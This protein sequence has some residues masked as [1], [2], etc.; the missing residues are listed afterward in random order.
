MS[1]N[2]GFSRRG[3]A[4]VL[5]AGA[6]LCAAAQTGA[7]TSAADTIAETA[8][9]HDGRVEAVDPVAQAQSLKFGYLSYSAALQ[10]MPDYA[11][12]RKQM[13][14]LKAKYDAEARR[15]EDEFNEKYEEFLEGQ[16]DFPQSI[17]EKRQNELQELLDRNIAFR[18]ESR[19]L[20]EAAEKDIFAPLHSK[21]ASLIKTVGARNGYAF[22]INTDNNA[23]PFINQAQGENLNLLVSDYFK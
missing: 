15:V 21:L 16:R 13:A 14:D 22:I 11:A 7:E 1:V 12:A 8:A 3:L 5:F 6:A 20:L 2:R 10:A 18:D 19:R 23:C 9:V 4:V 17:L